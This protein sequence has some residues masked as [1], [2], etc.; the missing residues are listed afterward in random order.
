MKHRKQA[1]ALQ[2]RRFVAPPVPDDENDVFGGP[3]SD[4]DKATGDKSS[5]DKIRK[6]DEKSG[7]PAIKE[8]VKAAETPPVTQAKDGKA[9]VQNKGSAK[10]NT[11]ENASNAS[12]ESG[13]SLSARQKKRK[14]N[15]EWKKK[16]EAHQRS[17]VSRKAV[18]SK[19]D[20][21][22]LDAPPS[23]SNKKT[24]VV[25]QDSKP[26][27]GN[28]GAGPKEQTRSPNKSGGGTTSEKDDKASGKSEKP[29]A[30]LSYAGMS[31][32]K[33]NVSEK[34]K[35]SSEAESESSESES[36][37]PKSSKHVKN[38]KTGQ[39]SK[40]Q[41]DGTSE[42]AISQRQ[43]DH[44]KRQTSP[45]ARSESGSESSTP[46]KITKKS[47]EKDDF[48]NSAS[49]SATKSGKKDHQKRSEK[50]VKVEKAK[51]KSDHHMAQ[52]DSDSDNASSS[53]DSN[54]EEEPASKRKE[55]KSSR[56]EKRK[57]SRHAREESVSGDES[58]RESAPRS[59]RSKKD[60]KRKSKSRER[61][62]EQDDSDDDGD[63]DNV[64]SAKRS[65]KDKQKKSKSRKRKREQDG[66]AED[67]DEDGADK[68]KPS[69][70]D[71][72]RKK[73]ARTE[74]RE[75]TQSDDDASHK[76]VSRGSNV[77]A[78]SKTLSPPDLKYSTIEVDEQ[79]GAGD[80]SD[81]ET[82]AKSAKESSDSENNADIEADA[83]S[84]SEA[85][86]K[87]ED[88]IVEEAPEGPAT[89]HFKEGK[90]SQPIEKPAA[91][92]SSVAGRNPVPHLT[93]FPTFKAEMAK[94]LERYKKEHP[95]HAGLSPILTPS[96]KALTTT[97]FPK[98]LMKAAHA[99]ANTL[100]QEYIEQLEDEDCD[101]ATR[102]TKLLETTQNCLLKLSADK[103]AAN[104]GP[105][106]SFKDELLRIVQARKM[107]VDELTA[108]IGKMQGEIDRTKEKEC[109]KG[110][111][112]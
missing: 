48:F 79:A 102:I 65:K 42:N 11:S 63:H 86:S 16:K 82:N 25:Q 23:T 87:R 60:K 90:R 56:D 41:A 37:T 5:K 6:K 57:S 74:K 34:V 51:R 29:A 69:K 111:K 49:D 109:K 106:D 55:S 104:G 28:N 46:E 38:K 92:S 9:N 31:E 8:N 100:P 76:P 78:Q 71:E 73:K 99:L 103:I 67:D 93:E 80:D 33:E 81:N 50:S 88:D 15:N 14:K 70:K 19:G 13:L 110:R 40:S 68:K 30:Q 32:K 47:V 83:E 108:K 112:K 64:D 61:T 18:D 10:S 35:E 75:Q 62:R 89:N 52:Q 36:D 12:K 94:Q 77:P 1:E 44:K 107:E 24:P 72:H 95:Y 84:E 105:S 96:D 39:V 43:K 58:S 27:T 7:K 4:I 91:G 66:S 54:D 21:S 98:A 3:F 2:N 17:S 22:M 53:D 20:V 97:P 26:E 101:P 45:D 59:K 85:G